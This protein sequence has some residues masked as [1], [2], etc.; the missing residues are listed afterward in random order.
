[1]KPA[2]INDEEN[3]ENSQTRG[4]ARHKTNLFQEK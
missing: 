1:M 3:D 4:D 2:K